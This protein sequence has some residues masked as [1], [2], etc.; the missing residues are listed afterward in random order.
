MRKLYSALA[1]T[2][3]AGVVVQ[4]ATIAFGV[5]GMVSYVM[6]GG[7]VDKALLES[8]QATYTGDLGF[9]IHSV[10]GGVVLHVVALVLGVVS[11][12]VRGVRRAK[13]LAWG[14]FL[15]IF[16]Q[17]SAG[18]MLTDMPYVGLFHGANA[19]LILVLAVYTARVA[20]K[21]PAH[22]VTA[23]EPSSSVLA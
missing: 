3:A 1:W 9:P 23:D 14:I 10:V 19:L 4:A 7:V 21:G 15:L 8:Q 20:S 2:I 18:Y 16:I 13:T 6:E 12:F 17:G 11:F 22:E 5:G